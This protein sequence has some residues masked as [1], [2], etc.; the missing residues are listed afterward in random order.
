MTKPDQLHTLFYSKVKDLHECEQKYYWRYHRQLIPKLKNP[1]LVR[2]AYIH[3]VM[4]TTLIL[5]MET[6]SIPADVAL[7]LA[8]LSCEDSHPM[9]EDTKQEAK[10]MALT[11][12]QVLS[13]YEVLE[14]ERKLEI[15]LGDGYI[16]KAKLD[17]IVKSLDG[18]WQAEYKSTARY[19]SNLRRLYHSGI[20][21]FIYL[22]VAKECGYEL[23]GTKM[24]IASAKECLVE[25]VIS[26]PEQLAQA[27]RYIY[28]SLVRVRAVEEGTIPLCRNRSACVTLLSECPYRPLC[29]ETASGA[30]IEDTIDMMYVEESP[31][32][33]YGE[34]G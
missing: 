32:A 11:L 18:M 9:S 8:L 24:F 22:Y 13:T 19:A 10:N 3:Q 1:N 30:Y 20:Q 28:D 23:R 15:E 27:E 12:W 29:L 25:E 14:T 17:G 31:L 6:P 34:G 16:W 2:G 5:T 4:D 7:G 26:T 21:P 33:H